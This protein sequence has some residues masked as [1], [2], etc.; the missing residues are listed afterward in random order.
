[1]TTFAYAPWAA[2]ASAFAGLVDD[3]R[4]V[5]GCNIENLL[6]LRVALCAE[7]GMVSGSRPRVV[8][9]SRCGTSTRTATA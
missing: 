5:S 8:G 2:S 6:R 3:R 4:I 1:M 7:C 9:S